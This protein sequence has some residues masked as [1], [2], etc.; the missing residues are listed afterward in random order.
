MPRAAVA[1]SSPLGPSSSRTVAV[2]ASSTLRTRFSSSTRSSS[3]PRWA[4]PAWVTVSMSR[5]R[6]AAAFGWLAEDVD[7]P[8]RLPGGADPPELGRQEAPPGALVVETLVDAAG[9]PGDG[10]QQAAAG[11]REHVVL[12]AVHPQRRPAPQRLDPG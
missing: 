3:T 5:S 10:G 8:K 1:T 6:S 2:S 7:T 9:G 12:P 4:R 11:A